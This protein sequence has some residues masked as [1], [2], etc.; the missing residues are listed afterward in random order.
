[1]YQ[2]KQTGYRVA[3]LKVSYHPAKCR[4]PRIQT[5]K[6][7]FNELYRFY[8]E[9]TIALQEQMVVM[10]LGRNARVLGIYNLSRGG[11]TG[12][13]VDI[14]LVLS[15]AL[16]IAATKI[17]SHTTIQVEHYALLMQISVSLKN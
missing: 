13:V 3:E 14:R 11:I 8:P 4:K 7:A 5:A 2:M 10:Y 15:V 12:T 17:I 1:M 16:S 9:D 6:D